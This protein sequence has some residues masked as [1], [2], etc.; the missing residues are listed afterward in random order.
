MFTRV[1]PP[2]FDRG[3]LS[4]RPDHLDLGFTAELPTIRLLLPC[5]G[6]DA[7]CQALSAA[8]VSYTLAGAYEVSPSAGRVLKRL[9]KGQTHFLHLGSDE[10]D[11]TKVVCRTKTPTPMLLT[12]VFRRLSWW[13]L[14]VS[15]C[16]R[17]RWQR[18]SWGFGCDVGVPW[19]VVIR[20]SSTIYPMHMA[21]YQGH[22]AHRGVQWASDT[23]GETP[24]RPSSFAF[25][26]GFFTCHASRDLR[27]PFSSWRMCMG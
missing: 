7:P 3:V 1:G 22:L 27:S 5:A 25:C 19:P 26:S 20:S 21:W 16:F 24:G 6:W 4:S 2:C 10:G 14:L 11:V 17:G 12:L 13:C 23:L 18:V 15:G 9:H 8:G